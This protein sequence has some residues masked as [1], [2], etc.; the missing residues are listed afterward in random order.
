MGRS[1]R[2][3]KER[4]Y[5]RAPAGVSSRGSATEQTNH[6][7]SGRQRPNPP[8]SEIVGLTI[9]RP[10]NSREL[11]S[12]RNANWGGRRDNQTGRPKLYA[13]DEERKAAAAARRRATRAATKNPPPV[14]RGRPPKEIPKNSWGGTRKG[15][16]RPPLYKTPEERR[17]RNREISRQRFERWIAIPENALLVEESRRER[18]RR[19]DWHIIKS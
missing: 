18:L 12:E 4:Q 1:S 9:P 17:A 11:P 19:G 2:R 3:K 16:G 8:I 6:L 14:P 15:A 7:A 13:S 5:L 10:S